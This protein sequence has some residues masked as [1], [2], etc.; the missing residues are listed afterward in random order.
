[1]H[2]LNLSLSIKQK[3]KPIRK[4]PGS[5]PI[6][7]ILLTYIIIISLVTGVIL[8]QDY[9]LQHRQIAVTE[10]VFCLDWGIDKLRDKGLEITP[11]SRY[12][13]FDCII[14]NKYVG[15]VNKRNTNKNTY[16]TTILP[17][18]KLLEYRK[19]KKKL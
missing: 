1:M 8:H 13:P 9:L 7:A 11:T 6:T 3:I 17:Y 19:V 4:H 14:N 18:S 16:H 5:K 10:L 15:E 12:D 2:S